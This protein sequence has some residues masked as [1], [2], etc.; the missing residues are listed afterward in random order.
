MPSASQNTA[1]MI[2]PADGTDLVFFG[3]GQRKTFQTTHV[4]LVTLIIPG[5]QINVQI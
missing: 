3:V 5:S 1:A 4:L 2:F